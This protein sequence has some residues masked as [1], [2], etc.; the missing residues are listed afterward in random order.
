VPRN[1][2]GPSRI[3]LV[4]GLVSFAFWVTALAVVRPI[5]ELR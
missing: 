4:G 5:R 3:F 2:I 1:L